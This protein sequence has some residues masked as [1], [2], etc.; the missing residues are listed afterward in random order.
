M[1]DLPTDCNALRRINN[2]LDFCKENCEWYFSNKAPTVKC[3]RF[4]NRKT[5]PENVKML[6]IGVPDD[7]YAIIKE[8]VTKKFKEKDEETIIKQLISY[9]LEELFLPLAKKIN[10]ESK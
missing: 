3:K 4:F 7:I 5:T 9:T 6:K 1:G 8:A 10:P 2:Q